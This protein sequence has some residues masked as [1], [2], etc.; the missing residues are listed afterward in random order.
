MY[1]SS[2]SCGYVCAGIKSYMDKVKSDCSKSK[3]VTTMFG[4]HREL[5]HIQSKNPRLRAKVHF[6]VTE[7]RDI[8]YTNVFTYKS[9]YE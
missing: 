8:T 4:R 2:Q 6:I 7:Y 5:A 9:T 1:Q 3:V